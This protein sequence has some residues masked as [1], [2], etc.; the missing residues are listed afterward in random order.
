MA[1]EYH[2]NFVSAANS[3]A[4]D[5]SAYVFFV[6][7]FSIHWNRWFAADE[8]TLY[9]GGQFTLNVRACAHN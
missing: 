9:A 8:Y 4:G 7:V 3:Y 1:T 2:D 5:D 6:F